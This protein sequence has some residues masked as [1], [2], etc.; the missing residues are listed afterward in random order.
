MNTNHIKLFTIAIIVLPLLLFLG[1]SSG[2][3]SVSASNQDDE[4]AAMYKKNTCF[5]CHKADASKGFDATKEDAVLVQAILKG[6]KG[7]KPPYMPAYEGKG[8]DE[9]KA[10]ALV[11]YMKGLRAGGE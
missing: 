10:Q 4:A 9:A 2:T 1:I 7:E 6:V 3:T 11:T 5:A 8:M